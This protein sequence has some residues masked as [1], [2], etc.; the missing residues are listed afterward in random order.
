MRTLLFLCSRNSVRIQL[1][2]N[3][4]GDCPLPFAQLLVITA[5]DYPQWKQLITEPLWNTQTH[6]DQCDTSHDTCLTR[7]TTSWLWASAHQWL[8]VTS[9]SVHTH[10]TAFVWRW[11]EGWLQWAAWCPHFQTIFAHNYRGLLKSS[12]TWCNN[13]R[14]KLSISKTM[15]SQSQIPCMWSHAS[16][17]SSTQQHRG[18]S[19]FQRGRRVWR[20]D[21]KF[22]K[23]GFYKN[24]M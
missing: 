24:M 9:T 19:T 5:K 20:T 12:I 17:W 11:P 7:I 13:N 6:S 14:L 2:S 3:N 22:P 23:C 10:L 1:Q 16:R 4:A 18:I 8:K 21:H 15:K